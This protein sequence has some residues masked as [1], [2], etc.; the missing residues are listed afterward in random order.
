MGNENRGG[1]GFFAGFLI[2][3][4]VGGAIAVL[5]SQEETRDLLLGKAREASSFA[6]DATDDL[7]GKVSNAATQWQSSAAELYARGKEVVDGARVNF[8]AAVNEGVSAA[9]RARDELR[10]RADA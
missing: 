5:V 8:D 9:D 4:L 6:M 10:H 2:G 1:G 7:R 3:G